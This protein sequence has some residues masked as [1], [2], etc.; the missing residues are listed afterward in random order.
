MATLLTVA[1]APR[2]WLN[3]IRP[4]RACPPGSPAAPSWGGPDGLVRAEPGPQRRHG[5]LIQQVDDTTCGAVVLVV[6]RTAIDAGY[7]AALLTGPSPRLDP[8]RFGAVQRRVHRESTRFWPQALGTSPWGMVGWLRRARVARLR[9]R[10][11]DAAD[12]TDLGC[13][14]EEVDAATA[15]GWAVPLLVGSLVPRHWCL[16]LPSRNAAGWLVFEP[17]SGTVRTVSAPAVQERRLRPLLG[18]DDLQALL[19]PER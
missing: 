9:V 7:R 5:I 10:L 2:R 4:A 14:V 11:V 12:R 8:N 16:A 17:S 19:L 1:L 6:L 18:Y 15:A 3:W 13:A